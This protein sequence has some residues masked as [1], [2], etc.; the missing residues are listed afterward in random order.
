MQELSKEILQ[1]RQVRKTKKQK[2]AFIQLLQDKLNE[3]IQI[4]KGGIFKSRNIIIGNIEQAEYIL[5]AHYDTQP[6][7][8][9]CNLVTPKNK[10]ITILIAIAQCIII[11]ICDFIFSFLLMLLIKDKN[12][13]FILDYFF[14]LFLL[15]LMFFGPANKHTANDNTSG[16][17]ALIE[18][19]HNPIIKEKAAFVFFDHEE[20]GLLSSSYFAKKHKKLLQ[21]KLVI[22]LDCVGDGDTLM[23]I[24]SKTAGKY[25]EKISKAFT[26]NYEK[27]ILIEDAKSCIYP[28]DQINFKNNIALAAMKYS[29]RIG[30]YLDCIHT[31][32]DI[33]FD[34][35][36]IH[37]IISGIESLLKEE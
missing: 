19:L 18:A 24:L 32:K 28:S 15:G 21:N 16:V 29:P 33:H 4:E 9:F 13:T 27:Q 37:L 2:S 35:R 23:I 12:I 26:S 11:F 6:V 14:L 34:E 36:N 3:D 5:T 22:N 10:L 7:L 25:R 8:P 30:Y 1:N 31:K 17:I 20:V